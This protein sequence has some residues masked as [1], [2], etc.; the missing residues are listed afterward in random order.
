MRLLFYS[1]TKHQYRYFK[2]LSKNLK[3]ESRVIFFPSLNISL[4]GLRLLEKIDTKS[5]LD[6]KLK[7]ID[8]K[9]SGSLYKLLYKIV[10]QFQIPWVIMTIYRELKSYRPDYL[11]L[12]NGKKFH[13]ALALEVAKILGIEPILFEN[14]VLPETTTMDFKGVNASNSLSKDVEFYRALEYSN[15]ELP[16]VLEVRESKREKKEFN[17]KLPKRYIFVPFQVSYDTQ[18]IQHSPWIK[19]MFELFNIVEYLSKRL[20]ILFVIKEHPSDR[21]SSYESLY[22]RVSKNIEFS[23]ESTQTL[24]ENSLAVV[25]INSS[26]AI[27]S[28]LFKKRV[29]VLGEAFFAINEIVKVASSKEQILE[30]L[31]EIDSWV[32]NKSLI[33]N[34]LYYLYYDYLIPT[35]WRRADS[36]HFKEIESRIMKKGKEDGKRTLL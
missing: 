22:K 19:D 15:R 26:V 29:I 1:L 33:D 10:L 14:G 13:Q 5:I 8:I 7:E 24:I 35:N 21:V 4:D 18:I 25:T 17:R 30:I 36:R 28:L 20:D 32:I 12:W 3:F 27:E 2:K 23:T 6:I 16:K 34:F 9:Y 31:K 11:V